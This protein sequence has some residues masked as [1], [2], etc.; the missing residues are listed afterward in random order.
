MVAENGVDGPSQWITS[1]VS[2]YG[3]GISEESGEMLEQPSTVWDDDAW[4]DGLFAARLV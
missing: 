4:L 3:P 2:D 1:L